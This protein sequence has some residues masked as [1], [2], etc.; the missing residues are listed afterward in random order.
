VDLFPTFLELAGQ[1]LPADLKLD[2]Q[3]I[4][5]AL[6]GQAFRRTRPIHWEWRGGHG[7]PY[8]W[9]HLGIRD[10]R[11]KL[12]VNQ[13]LSRTELYDIEADWGETTNV[14]RANPDIVKALKKKALA[15]K[16]TLPTEP[17]AHCFSK[18]RMGQRS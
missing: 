6:K 5:A 13:E 16:Q 2:G 9:P 14:A 1:P 17:T 12:L 4:V 11:W 10:G 8:L 15:W 7:P 18:M 3:S